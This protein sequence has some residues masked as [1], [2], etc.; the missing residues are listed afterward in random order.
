MSL[1]KEVA[2]GSD[3]WEPGVQESQVHEQRPGAQANTELPNGARQQGVTDGSGL[4]ESKAGTRACGPGFPVGGWGGVRVE[5]GHLHQWA[6]PVGRPPALPSPPSTP[7]G[8]V[9]TAGVPPL[10]F[11]ADPSGRLT[12]LLAP[13]AFSRSL[14]TSHGTF[15]YFSS[16]VFLNLL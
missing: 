12:E 6:S 16:A 1:R 8:S 13:D 4:S 14:Q 9:L 10:C 3:P 11:S 7:C 15:I 2:P 5:F